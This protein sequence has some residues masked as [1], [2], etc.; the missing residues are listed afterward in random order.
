MPHY[1]GISLLRE[2]LEYGYISMIMHISFGVGGVGGG[3]GRYSIRPKI[4]RPS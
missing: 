3:G 2:T 4:V 1:V